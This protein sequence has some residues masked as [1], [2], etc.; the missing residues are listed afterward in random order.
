MMWCRSELAGGGSSMR[1]VCAVS[2]V[3]KAVVGAMCVIQVCCALV[4]LWPL[5]GGVCEFDVI[6]QHF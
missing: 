4:G 1:P 6:R 5:V 2:K 3:R